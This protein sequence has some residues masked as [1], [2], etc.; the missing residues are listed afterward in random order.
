MY[1]SL[2]ECIVHISV[3]I[4]LLHTG[5][6][7]SG[8]CQGELTELCRKEF[9]FSSASSQTHQHSCSIRLW[10]GSIRKMFKVRDLLS[11]YGDMKS[12]LYY[13][14]FVQIQ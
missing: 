11:K 12:K 6:P 1:S 7:A 2:T 9:I 10:F 3:C 13:A 14:C 8:E 5:V 4:Y